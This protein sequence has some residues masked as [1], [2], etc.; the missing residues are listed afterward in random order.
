MKSKIV[1]I[2]FTLHVFKRQYRQLAIY[3]RQ[4]FVCLC[5]TFYFVVGNTKG[6]KKKCN[7]CFLFCALYVQMFDAVRGT[8][9]LRSEE[10]LILIPSILDVNIM[11]CFVLLKHGTVIL[12]GTLKIN[13]LSNYLLHSTPTL[14]SFAHPYIYSHITS[15]FCNK[16]MKRMLIHL[17]HLPRRLHQNYLCN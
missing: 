7:L 13:E 14:Y 6:Q 10:V 4:L 9:R 8:F 16:Y 17:I 11:L 2:I 5:H 12:R 1:H 3:Y 15:L